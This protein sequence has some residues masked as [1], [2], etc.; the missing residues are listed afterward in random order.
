MSIQSE[1]QNDINLISSSPFNK[2]QPMKSVK[3]LDKS[4]LNS[5]RQ[6]QMKNKNSIAQKCDESD[7][8]DQSNNQS[9]RNMN[10]FKSYYADVKQKLKNSTNNS[11][12]SRVSSSQKV[13]LKNIRCLQN[14]TQ[15]TE[16][17]NIKRQN[18]KL[19]IKLTQGLSQLKD[20]LARQLRVQ[21][22]QFFDSYR[23]IARDQ[24]IIQMFHAWNEQQQ[25]LQQ[26]QLDELQQ[27]Q[28]QM[29]QE[30]YSQVHTALPDISQI[31]DINTRK[32]S[33]DPMSDMGMENSRRFS[34][35]PNQQNINYLTANQVFQPQFQHNQ[36][37][38]GYQTQQMQN[39][40][41]SNQVQSNQN[42]FN[43]QNLIEILTEKIKAEVISSLT[44]QTSKQKAE[45]KRNLHKNGYQNNNG[46]GSLQES[47]LTDLENSFDKYQYNNSCQNQRQY[48]CENCYSQIHNRS[49][50]H[51]HKKHT[52]YKNESKYNTRVQLQDISNIIQNHRSQ[53]H[54]NSND[55][56]QEIQTSSTKEILSPGLL[57]K[58]RQL[59]PQSTRDNLK[60][61]ACIQTDN[62]QN[63]KISAQNSQYGLLSN[64]SNIF[65]YSQIQNEMQQPFQ[66]QNILQQ[67]QQNF[68]QSV[69]ST[70]NFQTQVD[71]H[72]YHKNNL[73]NLE[74]C[75]TATFR[76]LR[77]QIFVEQKL[78]K[79]IK[80]FETHNI[81]SENINVESSNKYDSYLIRNIQN[82]VKGSSINEQQQMHAVQSKSQYDINLNDSSQ[83][84]DNHQNI[85]LFSP[86][87]DNEFLDATTNAQKDISNINDPAGD[88]SLVMYNTGTYQLNESCYQYQDKNMTQSLQESSQNYSDKSHDK[89]NIVLEHQQQKTLS[90]FENGFKTFFPDQN[91]N[92]ENEQIDKADSQMGKE[93]QNY[94]PNILTQNVLQTSYL[95]DKKSQYGQVSQAVSRYFNDDFEDISEIQ[96]STN[97]VY[98]KP[99]H[100]KMSSLESALL[101]RN[102]N[103]EDLLSPTSQNGSQF[104][105][106]NM[107]IFT[108]YSGIEKKCVQK[109]PSIKGHFEDCSFEYSKAEEIPT[110]I[111]SDSSFNDFIDSNQ[112]NNELQF[113]KQYSNKD[114]KRTSDQS[115]QFF[116]S[117]RPK[118]SNLLV[119]KLQLHKLNVF[120]EN[121]KKQKAKKALQNLVLT[122]IDN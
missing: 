67:Q 88:L 115:Y 9:M 5:F 42:I 121:D 64:Q 82:Q 59:L 23:Q 44:Q 109:K 50:L 36:N 93:T 90:M 32:F 106:E 66:R 122:S 20:V 107:S 120:Q 24:E 8:I 94:V 45:E 70:Q 17:F 33:L 14:Q 76:E 21:C 31:S 96:P 116:Q 86:K 16:G 99:N 51:K 91:Y 34:Q 28:Q 26:S 19:D 100:K 62:N 12:S 97:N 95:N 49:K 54:Q 92:Y 87:R 81:N 27:Q 37:Q 65:E 40:F 6:F 119:P 112:P 78:N 102:N 1:T 46:Q 101:G 72:I 15:F 58:I 103:N 73:D 110:K 7:N 3:Y 25:E 113:H 69:K 47:F 10:N 118:Q 85:S 98:Q 53:N 52:N 35:Q 84:Y 39:H 68:L 29:N 114:E 4:N 61:S 60:R 13:N 48:Q 56:I 89:S 75:G 2:L 63:V 55:S 108:K 79:H 74:T 57:N 104:R 117:V 80:T 105:N 41:M 38:N 83:D 18:S 77:E 22:K 71:E 11:L 30:L 43:K 111:L